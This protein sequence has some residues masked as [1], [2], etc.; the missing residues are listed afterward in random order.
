M[1]VHKTSRSAWWGAVDLA[2]GA[3]CTVLAGPLSVVYRRLAQEWQIELNNPLLQTYGPL[4]RVANQTLSV[5]SKGAPDQACSVECYRFVMQA[6]PDRLIVRPALADRAVVCRP[7]SPLILPPGEQIQLFLSTPLWLQVFQP[8]AK[9]VADHMLLEAALAPY[10]E[11][12]FGPD[13]LT[14]ALCYVV[15]TCARLSIDEVSARD[16]YAI[17]PIRIHNEGDDEL[18]LERLNVP[19]PHLGL[20]ICETGR[21]WTPEVSYR[22]TQDNN[23][24]EFKINPDVSVLAKGAQEMT[25]PRS[26]LR[27]QTMVRAWKLL[28]G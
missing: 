11:T 22:R 13:T 17:T 23:K 18:V 5:D 15:Q 14:G 7:I 19:V 16:H 28:F 8:N 12:W 4:G 6:P 2:T 21:L 24:V 27:R 26:R 10:A 3:D 1:A 20:S 9:G 25:P